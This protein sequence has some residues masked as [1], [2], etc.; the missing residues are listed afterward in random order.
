MKNLT[1]FQ[2]FLL[3]VIVGILGSVAVGETTE[4]VGSRAAEANGTAT[5]GQILV[6]LPPLFSL[7]GVFIGLFKTY[8][9]NA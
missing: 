7:F 2:R 1:V 6:D 5:V 3:L 4:N 8:T 9:Q